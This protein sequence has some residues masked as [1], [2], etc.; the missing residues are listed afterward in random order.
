M[1]RISIRRASE[2]V[3]PRTSVRGESIVAKRWSPG[4]QSGGREIGKRKSEE[5]KG[6]GMKEGIYREKTNTED[7]LA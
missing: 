4:L 2:S 6:T 3:M 7:G 1:P 5:G